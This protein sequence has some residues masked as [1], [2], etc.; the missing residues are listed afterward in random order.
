MR[1]ADVKFVFANG[2]AFVSNNVRH[3]PKL[4]K[5]L[6]LVGQLDDAS[7]HVIFGFQIFLVFR[8]GRFRRALCFWPEVP[9]VG[10]CIPY[11][12]HGCLIMLLR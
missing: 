1:A 11:M 10:V 5:G 4:T 3:V 6:I 8:F 12:Y 7:Y 2:S 9:S